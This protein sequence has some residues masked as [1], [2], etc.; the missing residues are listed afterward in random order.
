[1]LPTVSLQTVMNLG[2]GL[3]DYIP[4]PLPAPASVSAPQRCK[5]VKR[6]HSPFLPPWNQVLPG[7][8][9]LHPLQ[10]VIKASPSLQLFL[11][12]I[13]LTAICSTHSP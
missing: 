3:E 5:R 10:L 13:L 12:G 7:H 4:A 8:D 1:M 9:G 11:A 6:I 2:V